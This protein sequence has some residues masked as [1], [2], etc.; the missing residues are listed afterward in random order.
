M[1]VPAPKGKTLAASTV[2]LL[3][4]DSRLPSG[5]HVSS[6]GL[7]PALMGGLAREDVPKFLRA[8]AQTVALVDAATA[9]VMRNA[10]LR[11]KPLGP[12]DR[13]W[14]AR[15]PSP[16]ARK[17]A[18]ELG[19]GLLKLA[20]DLWPEAKTFDQ[21]GETPIRPLVLGAIAAHANL[22]PT[23][24]V[25]LVFYDDAASAASALLKLDPGDPT[26]AMRLVL[27]T[28][29]CVEDRVEELA[30]LVS[31]QDIP[32]ASAAQAEQWTEKHAHMGR[33]LFRA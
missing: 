12:A 24:L 7:E 18:R 28:C 9:V 20:R 14:A 21:L 29:T 32:A 16:A 4:A 17:I 6:S 25:R 10:I 5:G 31:T 27:D 19:R 11:G 8:R 23:E 3:L 1:T 13:A 30:R 33:R 2:S 15:T 22:P 26:E